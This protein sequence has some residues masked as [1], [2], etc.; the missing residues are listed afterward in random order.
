[1]KAWR[2]TSSTGAT[3][4]ACPFRAVG[5]LL[6]DED[7]DGL[8]TWNSPNGDP[9][10]DWLVSWQHFED[11]DWLPLVDDTVAPSGRQNT[12]IGMSGAG[13]VRVVILVDGDPPEC[14]SISNTQA[15]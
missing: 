13:L 1:M 9:P 6:S 12:Q 4:E 8:V 10:A 11:P 15:F 3:A 2:R 7:G 5:L 14:A